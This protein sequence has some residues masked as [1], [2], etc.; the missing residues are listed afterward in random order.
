[1]TS[2]KF[3]GSELEVLR[4]DLLRGAPDPLQVAELLQVFLANNGYG[5]SQP[6][7]L[8]GGVPRRPLRL[9]AERSSEGTREPRAGHVGELRALEVDEV[10]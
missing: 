10:P 6:T 7:A 4:K 8:R 2:E 1:M 9:F 5:V 3:D